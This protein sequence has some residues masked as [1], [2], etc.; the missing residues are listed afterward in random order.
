MKILT[1]P[2]EI[3]LKKSDKVDDM[4]CVQEVLDGMIQTMRDSNGIGLAAPQ[5]GISQRFFVLDE[6]QLSEI[7]E[8][9]SDQDVLVMINPEIVDGMGEIIIQEGC[10]SIPGETFHVS[11]AYLIC[12][13]FEDIDGNKRKESFQGMTAAAIQHECD[14]LD[15]LVLAERESFDRRQ[16]IRQRLAG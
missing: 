2:N 3:L 1:W 16:E 11:R 9:E 7:D 6:K 14:H 13:K 10:L 4:S 5:V 15:G 12:V 8:R